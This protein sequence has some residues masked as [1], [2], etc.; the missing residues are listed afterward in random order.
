MALGVYSADRI[1]QQIQREMSNLVSSEDASDVSSMTATSTSSRQFK[2]RITLSAMADRRVVIVPVV[3]MLLK[4]WGLAV[5]IGIYFLPTHAKTTY[6]Q[7]TLSSVLI[8]LSVK[9]VLVFVASFR[10][11][12][13]RAVAIFFVAHAH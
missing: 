8:F 2:H 3:Y 11:G 9:L 12:I 13:S 5:D 7:N 4:F 1:L 6:R 10:T